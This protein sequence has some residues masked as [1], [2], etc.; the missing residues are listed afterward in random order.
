M[1]YMDPM[2][3]GIACFPRKATCFSWGKGH[4]AGWIGCLQG[5]LNVL[6]NH[7][8]ILGEILFNLEVIFKIPSRDTENNP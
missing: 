8:P 6:I 4:M 2:G 3:Y 7:H 1:A 5:L